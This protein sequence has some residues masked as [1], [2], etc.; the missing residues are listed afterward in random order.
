MA[1]PVSERIAKIKAKKE[2]LAAKLSKLEASEKAVTRKRDMRR[3][4]I[5]GGALLA[6]IEKDSLLASRIRSVLGDQ[7]TNPKDREFIAD[8]LPPLDP[9]ARYKTAT[10]AAS[11]ANVGN[12]T[13]RFPGRTTE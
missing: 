2:Q 11:P 1:K 10:P 7:V 9:F 8:L 12:E 3:K 13:T 6:A 4:I 5:V